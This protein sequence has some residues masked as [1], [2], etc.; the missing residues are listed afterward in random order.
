MNRTAL[1]VRWTRAPVLV[2]LACLIVALVAAPPAQAGL[3][4]VIKSATT[5]AAKKVGQRV[6]PTTAAP[7]AP[8]APPTFDETLLE[9][10]A[11]QL[12]HVLAGFKAARGANQGRGELVA[13]K[14]K[15]QD[16]AGALSEKFGPAIDAAQR[17]HN[18]AERCWR[19][20]LD[21]RQEAN[22]KAIEQKMRSDPAM[23]QK[24]MAMATQLGQA[25]ARGDTAAMLRIQAE[26]GLSGLTHADTLAAQQKCG[27]MPPLH[28][29]QAQ[30]ESLQDQVRKV[31]ADLRAM[32]GKSMAAQTK[33]SGL[34][35]A[36][37]AMARE[38]IEMYLAAAK[39]SPRPGGFS[40][41]E[42]AALGAHQDELAALLEA[43]LN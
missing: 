19:E 8:G 33:A 37:F 1:S 34:T 30:I 25:Q 23:Q 12:D 20:E 14:A 31:D 7:S 9:L 3:G 29:A 21:Q 40:E 2:V 41:S 32:D 4:S 17:K 35:A 27:A 6:E 5:K 38:R 43:P 16:E 36:Q 13:R 39:G 42:L 24:M 15:L 22:Q 10:N 26:F 11:G 28:P 18:D